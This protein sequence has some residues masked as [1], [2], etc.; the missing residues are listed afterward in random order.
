MRITIRKEKNKYQLV[1][2]DTEKVVGSF[3]TKAE[4]LAWKGENPEK[5]KRSSYGRF[6]KKE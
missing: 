2:R 5:P 3:E 6:I 1:D 4:A